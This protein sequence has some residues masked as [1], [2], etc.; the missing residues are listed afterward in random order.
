MPKGLQLGVVFTGSICGLED[1]T[2]ETGPKEF[3]DNLTCRVH[4][5]GPLLIVLSYEL[6]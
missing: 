3:I 6:I 2:F 5:V 1:L 4:G